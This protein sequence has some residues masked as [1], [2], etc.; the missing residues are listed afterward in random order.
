ML[1]PLVSCTHFTT[2]G[3]TYPVSCRFSFLNEPSPNPLY[4]PSTPPLL[5]PSLEPDA[6]LRPDPLPPLHRERHHRKSWRCC[7]VLQCVA[8][9]YAVCCS[10]ARASWYCGQSQH[11]A[12]HCNTSARACWC[13]RWQEQSV[14]ACC[15]ALQCVAVRC[16]ALQC[17]AGHCSALAQELAD[18]DSGNSSTSRGCRS[19]LRSFRTRCRW[20][21]FLSL[22]LSPA[23]SLSFLHSVVG[24]FVGVGANEGCGCC[25]N[26]GSWYT[27]SKVSFISDLVNL[28][29]SFDF[30]VT[31]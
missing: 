13:W 29:A 7:S 21:S 6:V 30:W 15:S 17:V 19:Q 24:T 2:L 12:V 4:P 16:S 27:F 9:R 14:A 10:S 31:T 20:Q 22:S 26:V 3:L 1:P 28:A 8:V 11:T 25:S 18:V 5:L 23:L